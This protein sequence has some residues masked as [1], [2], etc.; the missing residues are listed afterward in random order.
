MK[1]PECGRS[2]DGSPRNCPGCGAALP[3]YDYRKTADSSGG[4]WLCPGCGFRLSKN[5]WQCP[6]CGYR[7]P[8]EEATA[9][10]RDPAEN[11]PMNWHTFVVYALLPILALICTIRVFQIV[12]LSFAAGFGPDF[13]GLVC[14][15]L[16]ILYLILLLFLGRLFRG[17]RGFKDG[18][19]KRF[20]I[21]T[22]VFF[23][24]EIIFGLIHAQHHRS[25]RFFQWLYDWLLIRFDYKPDNF[26][27]RV[28]LFVLLLGGIAFILLNRLYYKRRET[29]FFHF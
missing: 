25:D 9:V 21:L 8:L 6:K 22:A 13:L 5:A 14:W 24:A 23:G 20:L 2:I 15:M 7:R 18:A 26:P 1:C 19:P 17:M 29:L 28:W 16:S 3:S 4:S 12:M 27:Y 11:L 10:Y